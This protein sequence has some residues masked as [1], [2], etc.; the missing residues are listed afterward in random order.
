V[1]GIGLVLNPRAKR[2]ARD[3][4]MRDRLARVL[5]D[6]GVVR[7]A[8]SEEALRAVVREFQRHGV[9]MVVVAG[10]DGTSHV[11]LSRLIE[12][13]GQ[14]AL[15]CFALLRGGTMNT[16]ARSFGIPRR[17]PESLL[18]AYARAYAAR[19]LRPMRFVEANVLHVEGTGYGFIF[20]T[21]AIH[22]FIAEYSRR[23]DRSPAW[24]AQILARAVGS[25]LVGGETIARVAR[26]W[27]GA[28]RFDDGAAFPERDYLAVGAS[29]CAQIGLGFRPFYRS[30]E[31]AGRFHMLGIHAS[32]GAFIAGLPRIWRARSLGGARTYEQLTRRAVLEPTHGEVA[33][34][35]DGDIYRHPGPLAVS[36]GP[37]LRIV[38]PE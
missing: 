4:D 19:A 33:F 21:G 3:P 27:H 18:A 2:T 29:T 32:A 35:L 38:V 28:V 17:K 7:V 14:A 20:G 12:G 34:T 26:R 13:W 11:T 37:R 30:A 9:D 10:G 1:A 22:G 16:V 23:E 25:Y 15:P 36:A 8:P 24:A 31:A 5:G 6:H